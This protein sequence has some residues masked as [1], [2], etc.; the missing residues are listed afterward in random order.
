MENKKVNPRSF[1]KSHMTFNR[2]FCHRLSGLPQTQGRS[3]DTRPF[4]FPIFHG[5]KESIQLP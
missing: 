5:I 1:N 4:T 2:R 3:V